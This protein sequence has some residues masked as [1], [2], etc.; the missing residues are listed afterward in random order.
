MYLLNILSLFLISGLL[1]GCGRVS[2]PAAPDDSFYPHTYV[3]R[4]SENEF[5]RQKT[6][7]AGVKDTGDNQEVIRDTN[8]H[9]QEIKSIK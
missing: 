6:D 4:S 7:T 2:K 9:L 8:T 5:N 3:V 1:M